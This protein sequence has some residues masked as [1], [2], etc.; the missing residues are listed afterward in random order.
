MADEPSG[1]SAQSPL[2]QY[3]Y[4]KC[5][6]AVVL[7]CGVMA[8]YLYGILEDYAELGARERRELAPS[9]AHL[10]TLMGI[11]RNSI[12][13]MLDGLV[14]KQWVQIEKRPGLRDRYLLPNR[15][16][17][18]NSAGDAHELWGTSTDFVEPT[19]TNIVH[20]IE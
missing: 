15:N 12:P 7:E 13:P 5:Y 8:A 3:G 9:H 6:R 16:R 10:A 17:H 2:Q 20:D 4:I 14:T 19:S 1:V 18:K 11:H